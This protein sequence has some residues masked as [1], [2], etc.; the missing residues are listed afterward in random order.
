MIERVK[1]R[2]ASVFVGAL[3]AGEAGFVNAIVHVVVDEGGKLGLFRR[4]I[5]RE[6]VDVVLCERAERAVEHPADVVFGVVD[7]AT[8][9]RVPKPGTVT[10]PS[11]AIGCL[12]SFLQKREA[13]HRIAAVA[14]PVAKRPAPFIADWIDHGHADDLFQS[15]KM[16]ND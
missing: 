2:A 6:K 15:L 16:P 13:I 12:V 1:E 5:V 11:Q 10:R 3:P 9:F 8:R 14:R 4:D 7:D